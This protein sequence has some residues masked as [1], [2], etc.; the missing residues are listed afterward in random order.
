MLEGF[1]FL[2]LLAPPGAARCFR[3]ELIYKSIGNP[4]SAV[5]SP[6]SAPAVPAAFGAGSSWP[7]SSLLTGPCQWLSTEHPLRCHLI[8]FPELA[9]QEVHIVL[10]PC[11]V[12]LVEDCVCDFLGQPCGTT[13]HEGQRYRVRRG[14]QPPGPR[15]RQRKRSPRLLVRLEMDSLLFRKYPST[16]AR[17]SMS[18]TLE[19][20]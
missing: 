1:P 5:L 3:S 6:F 12:E 10:F 11:L 19:R 15:G 13:P 14:P 2:S 4:K 8:P 9:L 17:A 20:P 18:S 16:S 7:S